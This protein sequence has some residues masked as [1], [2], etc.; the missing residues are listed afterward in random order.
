VSSQEGATIQLFS[1]EYV[2]HGEGMGALVNM[3]GNAV[4]PKLIKYLASRSMNIWSKGK[5]NQ[6]E[7]QYREEF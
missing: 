3:T 1:R 4:P 5:P 2:F 7:N 6:R